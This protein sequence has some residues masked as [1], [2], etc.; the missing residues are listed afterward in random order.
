MERPTH[1]DDAEMSK[2]GILML[3]GVT[4]KNKNKYETTK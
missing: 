1:T 3:K 4:A 2:N